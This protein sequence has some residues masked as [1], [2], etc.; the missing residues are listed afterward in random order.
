MAWRFTKVPQQQRKD[1][2]PNAQRRVEAVAV[3]VELR[4]V[5]VLGADVLQR[6]EHGLEQR[7]LDAQSVEDVAVAVVVREEPR[8][9]GEFQSPRHQPRV[10]RV[11]DAKKD[12]RFQRDGQG[13]P[14]VRERFEQLAP[15]PFFPQ[16]EKARL[17]EPQRLR[18][19][20][21]VLAAHQG[22]GHELPRVLALR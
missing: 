21:G 7:V 5:E 18:Q 15:I 20:A 3:L 10:E 19:Q 9:E 2:A 17:H 11:L 6:V 16:H 14:G 8:R 12:S 13:R 4:R 22:R 1:A